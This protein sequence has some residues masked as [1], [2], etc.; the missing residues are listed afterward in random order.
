MT[1]F[2]VL[3]TVGLGAV[4]SAMNQHAMSQNTRTV[5]DNLNFIMED[6][7]RNIRL[8]TNFHCSLSSGDSALDGLGMPIPQ[9]CN[10]GSHKIVFRAVSGSNITYAITDP[11]LG[12]VQITKTIDSGTPQI[13]NL[14]EVVVDYYKSGFVVV[15]SPV[16]DGLQ[17]V[18]NIGLSG[19]VTYKSIGANSN[20]SIQTTVESRPLDG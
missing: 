3:V 5:M 19:K 6:M 17:P 20:F 13:F 1:I 10:A 8:G 11:S 16:G 4:F 9:D 2:S 14:P 15:G 7:S 18:V 12:A